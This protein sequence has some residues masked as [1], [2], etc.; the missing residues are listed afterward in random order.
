MRFS[1]LICLIILSSCGGFSGGVNSFDL[2]AAQAFLQKQALS[3]FG[4]K[5]TNPSSICF[6]LKYI[7]YENESYEPLVSEDQVRATVAKANNVW[8]DCDISFILEDYEVVDPGQLDLKYQTEN[9]SELKDIRGKFKDDRRFLVVSTGKWQRSGSLGNTSANAW[10]SM[11]G[12][13]PYGIVLESPVALNGNLLA[14]ELGHYLSLRHT[15]DETQLMNP[16]IYNKSKQIDEAE[17]L[18]ARTAA[19]YYWQKMLR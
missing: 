5:K 19:F 6:G 17:C 11:P 16:V 15:A 7:V 9:L 14:H 13:S 4:C 18:K 2:F 10:T 12:S 3:P 8:S 1:I